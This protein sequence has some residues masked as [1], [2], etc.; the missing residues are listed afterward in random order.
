MSTVRPCVFQALLF[1]YG[2]LL[3]TS[4]ID[5]NEQGYCTLG[6]QCIVELTSNETLNSSSA[7]II[8]TGGQSCADAQQSDVQVWE[9]IV[10]PRQIGGDNSTYDLGVATVGPVGEFRMCWVSV[11][12]GGSDVSMFNV[13]AG[14]FLMAGPENITETLLCYVGSACILNLVGFELQASAKVEIR[15][16]TDCA[17]GGQ[18]LEY[19]GIQNPSDADVSSMGTFLLGLPLVNGGELGQKF[20]LCWGAGPTSGRTVFVGE[21]QIGGP[22]RN[23][24][25]QCA[26]GEDCYLYVSGAKLYDDLGASSV[27]ITVGEGSCALLS[28]AKASIN[29]L[30]NPGQVSHVEEEPAGEA[31]LVYLGRPVADVAGSD[32]ALCWRQDVST[33]PR[34]YRA[35]I[36]ADF[37]FLGPDWGQSFSCTLGLPCE[38]SLTGTGL[39]GNNSIVLIAAADVC[40]DGAAEIS[41]AYPP[42]A[43]HNATP[44]PPN[45]LYGL[46]T[47]LGAPPGEYKM[48]W[49]WDAII[50]SVAEHRIQVGTLTLLGPEYSLHKCVFTEPCVISLPGQGLSINNGVVIVS[51]GE[52]CGSVGI[53]L[54]DGSLSSLLGAASA[55]PEQNGPG[56]ATKY[57]LGT[58]MSGVPETAQLCW[59]ASSS[60]GASVQEFPVQIGNLTMAGPY[61]GILVE[62]RLCRECSFLVKGLDMDADD[63]VLM[64][65]PSGTCGDP[66]NME[67]LRLFG[68]GGAAALQ[69][70]PS[71]TF[72][73]S[74][75][76]KYTIGTATI[77]AAGDYTMCWSR[78]PSSLADYKLSIGTF[79]MLPLEATSDSNSSSASCFPLDAP[80]FYGTFNTPTFRSSAQSQE[81]EA[82]QAADA[83]ISTAWVSAAG[84]CSEHAA[85]C[86]NGFCRGEN[87]TACPASE[88][89]PHQWL[90]LDLQVT[91][92]VCKI[93]ISNGKPSGDAS[94]GVKELVVEIGPTNSGPWTLQLT[95]SMQPSCVVAPHVEELIPTD[96]LVTRFIRFK[97]S[98][99]W[100]AGAVSLDEI[101]VWGSPWQ[102]LQTDIDM[103]KPIPSP[104][105]TVGHRVASRSGMPLVAIGGDTGLRRI[106]AL[107]GR[108]IVGRLHNDVHASADGGG[109]WTLLVQDA[110]WSARRG[111]AAAATLGCCTAVLIGGVALGR[112]NAQLALADTWITL[113]AGQTWA[114]Q[115]DGQF[116]R[117]R[118]EHGVAF[119]GSD[120]LYLVGGS[121]CSR[122]SGACGF[123]VGLGKMDTLS[124]EVFWS[125]DMGRSWSAATAASPLQR[126]PG[127]HGFGLMPKHGTSGELFIIG[128]RSPQERALGD[129]WHTMDKGATWNPVLADAAFPARAFHAAVMHPD[130]TA[131]YVLGGVDANGS[132]LNDVWVSTDLGKNWKQRASLVGPR[133]GLSAIVDTSGE[134]LV[135]G[136][137]PA[138]ASISSATCI[139]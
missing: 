113:N 7:V 19:G 23:S 31:I 117:P 28:T 75:T 58:S 59:S 119:D 112:S 63:K 6:E 134:L 10:N 90:V 22:V 50:F 139:V 42:N 5:G 3:G 30:T 138:T 127:R 21:I 77:G 14:V 106:L 122:P 65:M 34:E 123:G 95:H 79:R 108:D 136:G 98:E 87:V 47:E 54:P 43:Q 11:T 84:T 15:N 111:H 8:L 137:E 129:I 82:L 88:C 78:Q 12:D 132:N 121:T 18:P 67:K 85:R 13:T 128:G 115:S 76:V 116:W 60:P 135:V 96:P 80:E 109:T 38:I 49:A 39:N 73:S 131:M 94:Y 100:G 104:G 64:I 126:Y 27:I 81:F 40:G 70:P 101:S 66:G 44:V 69:N 71:L 110:P 51:V 52:V 74:E 56:M 99:G 41:V 92:V 93:D 91:R 97:I 103:T 33:L 83:L 72:A 16:G 125:T 37:E 24:S 36:D 35:T 17:S 32:F 86:T 20:P 4:S 48:C 114:R 130:D 46:G 107:G 26:L 45:L 120:T 25:S 1:A 68:T 9:G 55:Q 118:F 133:R 57:Q 62:C 2:L 61:Q 124:N 102:Q 53:D 105:L 89:S 29:G